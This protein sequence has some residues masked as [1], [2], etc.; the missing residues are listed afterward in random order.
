[1]TLAQWT[2]TMYNNIDSIFVCV[3]WALFLEV[4]YY[5]HCI[6]NDLND[7]QEILISRGCFWTVWI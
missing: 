6:L 7:L 2:L 1:M 4:L 5:V 3:C